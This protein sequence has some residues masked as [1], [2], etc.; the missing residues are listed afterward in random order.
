MITFP[1]DVT[2]FSAHPDLNED[3]NEAELGR[4]AN[5]KLGFDEGEE[6]E[7]GDCAEGRV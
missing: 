4:R 3:P 6:T 5:V 7:N 1:V 2:V